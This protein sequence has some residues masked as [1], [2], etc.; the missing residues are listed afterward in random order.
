MTSAC[1]SKYLLVVDR[2]ETLFGERVHRAEACAG[3]EI[4]F[5]VR[6]SSRGIVIVRTTARYYACFQSNLF[7]ISS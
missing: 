2:V 3:K 6:I 4:A 5:Q 1:R 7:H